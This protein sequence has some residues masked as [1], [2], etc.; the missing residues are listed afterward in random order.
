MKLYIDLARKILFPIF[1]ISL[2]L[3]GELF[4]QNN[5]TL[6]FDTE[7]VGLGLTVNVISN[8]SLDIG[9]NYQSNFY[10]PDAMNTGI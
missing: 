5:V 10:Q 9:V 3:S 1:I 8:L 2:F 6:V 7:Q 4:A